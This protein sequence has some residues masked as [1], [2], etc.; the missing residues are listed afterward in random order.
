MTFRPV[1]QKLL[2]FELVDHLV[3]QLVG[4]IASPKYVI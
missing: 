1:V 4:Q 3:Y 2:T